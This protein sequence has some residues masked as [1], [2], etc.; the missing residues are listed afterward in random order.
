MKQNICR[1][2]TKSGYFDV[3][4]EDPVN[5]DGVADELSSEL[6]KQK[7]YGF[8][9]IFF[10]KLLDDYK[11]TGN[12]QRIHTYPSRIIFFSLDFRERLPEFAFPCLTR[13]RRNKNLR[14][15]YISDP[16][17]INKAL[18]NVSTDVR[19]KIEARFLCLTLHNFCRLV[20]IAEEP[21]V[22]VATYEYSNED[23]YLQM[24]KSNKM[25][26]FQSFSLNLFLILLYSLFPSYYKILLFS[27]SQK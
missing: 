6:L 5:I 25:G 13:S 8:W 22:T 2:I 15:Y 14:L 21:A 17:N 12:S 1:S 23:L 9:N 26:E 4:E 19:N 24:R 16:Y 11:I 3:M 27:R 20:A 7:K 10:V 18:D